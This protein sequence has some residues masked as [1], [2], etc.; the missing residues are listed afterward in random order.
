MGNFLRF[1]SE[2]NEVGLAFEKTTAKNV[3]KWLA[4]HGMSGEF[5]ASRFKPGKGQRS[6][7]FPD[8]YVESADGGFFIEC[9]QYSR[10]NMLNARFDIDENCRAKAKDEK[11]KGLAD[12]INGSDQ[13][14]RFREFM[15]SGQKALGG[16]KPIDVYA[17][18]AKFDPKKLVPRYNRMVRGGLVEADCKEF[19]TDVIRKST[20]GAMSCALAWRLASRDATW[21]ICRVEADFGPYLLGKYGGDANVKYIQ[22]GPNLFTIDPDDNPLGIDAPAFPEKIEGVFS[23]R[24]TPRFGVGGM[25][26]TPRSELTGELRSERDFNCRDRWPEL[27]GK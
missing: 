15:T 1:I 14:G 22:L 26:I 11:Y 4:E 7:N 17:G 18:K 10:A 16:A 24:F 12:A 25:Y 2:Q 21:D 20:A 8:V 27:K 13:F 3:N 6:E 19:D 23:L 5:K 9:K